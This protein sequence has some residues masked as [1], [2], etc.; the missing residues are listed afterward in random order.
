MNIWHYWKDGK[1]FLLIFF[2]HSFRNFQQQTFRNKTVDRTNSELFWH[3]KKGEKIIFSKLSVPRISRLFYGYHN[4][5]LM[6]RPTFF[7]VNFQN[8]F[9]KGKVLKLIDDIILQN[10][11]FEFSCLENVE[12]LYNIIV[13]VTST[14]VY[15]IT[16]SAQS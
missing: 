10:S 9:L 4:E 8:N 7:I 15:V 14:S 3:L 1:C 2:T 6:K 11:K 12:G 13:L 5:N 16:K